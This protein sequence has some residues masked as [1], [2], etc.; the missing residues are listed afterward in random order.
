MNAKSET[1]D[2]S[3]VGGRRERERQGYRQEILNAAEQVFGRKGYH[4]ATIEEIA[5]EAGFA[6][7]TIYNFFTGK[8]KLYAEAI[9]RIAENFIETFEQKVADNPEPL[10]AITALINFRLEHFEQHRG[11]FRVAFDTVHSRLDTR[12]SFP[13]ECRPIYDRYIQSLN[14]IFSRGIETGVFEDR[15]PL[16]LTLCLDGIINAFVGHWAGQESFVFTPQQ[17]EQVVSMILKT[18]GR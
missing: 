14:E 11:F 3:K 2:K 16:S 7:G 8:D 15:D 9:L 5:Q 6:V 18:V 1:R 13:D 12:R 17:A 4:N 10:A